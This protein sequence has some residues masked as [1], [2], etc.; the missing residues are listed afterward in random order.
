[1][2]GWWSLVRFTHV[3]S[4]MVWV[5][6]QLT[7]S[8]ILLPTVRRHLDLE[9]RATVLTGVGRR[10]GRFTVTLFLPLQ[11][12]TGVALAWHKGVTIPSLADPG[13]GRTLAAKLVAFVLVMLA[14]GVHGWAM[15]TRRQLLARALAIASLVGSLAI[16]LLAT[17][18]PRS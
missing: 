17:A 6:G 12:G 2:L 10:F 3:V 15:G 11:V 9:G 14:A 16:V 4:A 8:A 18:L 1:M 5:G 7:I 13:Y